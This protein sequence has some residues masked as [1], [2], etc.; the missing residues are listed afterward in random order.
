[1]HACVPLDLCVF[2][3][4]TI[5]VHSGGMVGGPNN[6][7]RQAGVVTRIVQPDSVNMQTAVSPHCHI[8]V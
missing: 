6:V 7:L 1:M 3:H 2:V 4:T 5:N 8:L